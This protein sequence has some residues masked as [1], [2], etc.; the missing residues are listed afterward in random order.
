M[1]K[2]INKLFPK[3]Y[4]VHNGNYYYILFS[5]FSVKIKLNVIS[6]ID[7]CEHLYNDKRNSLNLV[8]LG[9]I[10]IETDNTYHVYSSCSVY[11]KKAK[12]HSKIK[13]LLDRKIY[14]LSFKYHKQNNFRW[15]KVNNS[16]VYASDYVA[17]Y[18]NK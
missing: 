18:L 7:H 11:H 15:Y 16:N 1:K 17:Q 4:N 13:G 5:L 8:L 6:Q 3:V 10:M 14:I 12:T 9:N 2:L